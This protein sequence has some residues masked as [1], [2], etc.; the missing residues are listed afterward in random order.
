MR[1]E[2]IKMARSIC[3]QGRLPLVTGRQAHALLRGELSRSRP[4]QTG[5]RPH[6]HNEFEERGAHK[7]RQGKRPPTLNF[8]VKTLAG[9]RLN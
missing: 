6:D 1:I 5:N 7:A 9:Q 2:D 8:I 3:R 4:S